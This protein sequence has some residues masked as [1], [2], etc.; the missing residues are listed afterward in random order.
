ML[1]Y[2]VGTVSARRQRCTYEET[3]DKEALDEG[4][5]ERNPRAPDKTDLA[6]PA[7]ADRGVRSAETGEAGAG[8]VDN[9][10]VVSLGV[11]SPCIACIFAISRI[12]S[13][14]AFRSA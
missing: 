13:G 12:L 11:S 4:K 6:A 3:R 8:V 5:I 9:S 14:L 1:C 2:F 10:S 7:A